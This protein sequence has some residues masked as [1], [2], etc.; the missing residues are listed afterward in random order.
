[1]NLETIMIG[2]VSLAQILLMFLLAVCGIMAVNLPYLKYKGK[3]ISCSAV[4]TSKRM[5]YSNTPQIRYAGNRWNYLVTFL[6][7]DGHEV[8]LYVI[9]SEYGELKEGMEGNL[10]YQGKKMLSFN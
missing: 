5:E 10:V 4:I 1:M 9:E 7:G 3:K 2:N 6:C 8:D